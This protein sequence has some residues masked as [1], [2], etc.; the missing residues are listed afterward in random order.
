MS[1]VSKLFIDS[2]QTMHCHIAGTQGPLPWAVPPPIHGSLSSQLQFSDLH[3]TISGLAPTIS[4]NC[5][6][7]NVIMGERV[8]CN[9][10]ANCTS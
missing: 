9:C 2:L 1:P 3:V 10:Q 4:Q 5:E 8:L 7:H 6:Y